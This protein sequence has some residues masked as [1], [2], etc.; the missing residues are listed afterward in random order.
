MHLTRLRL[1]ANTVPTA[2]F[3]VVIK[4]CN[5][6]I[7]RPVRAV[8]TDPPGCR[9]M[10]RPLPGGSAKIRLSAVDFDRRRSIERRN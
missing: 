1:F 2:P 10:N 9:Y 6:D 8:H 3:K 5:F 4:V 7:Y